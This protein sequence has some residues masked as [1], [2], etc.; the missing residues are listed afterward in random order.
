MENQV[1]NLPRSN[2]EMTWAAVSGALQVQVAIL[3]RSSRDMGR[4]AFTRYVQNSGSQA[5]LLAGITWE[6]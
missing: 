2:K 3:A 1:I 6:L 4:H 5:W